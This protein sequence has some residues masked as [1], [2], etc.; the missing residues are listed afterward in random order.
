LSWHGKLLSMS[1][2]KLFLILNSV[3]FR[4]MTRDV[5][6]GVDMAWDVTR[7]V[8]QGVDMAWDVTQD[9][10]R[11]VDMTQDVTQDVTQGVTRDVDSDP[12]CR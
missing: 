4:D 3:L 5:A 9:V 12:G 8:A 1:E 11:D 7:D 6:Q 10:T 2:S